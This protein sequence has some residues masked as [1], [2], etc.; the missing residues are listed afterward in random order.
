SILVFHI[1]LYADKTA[2]FSGELGA[3][4]FTGS[5]TAV[6][7]LKNPFSISLLLNIK[8]LNNL[9]QKYKGKI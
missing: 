6:G 8:R 4:P 9:M 7:T 5:F 2:A 1:S 3:Y